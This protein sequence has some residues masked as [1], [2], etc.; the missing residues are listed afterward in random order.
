M[1]QLTVVLLVVSVAQW[2]TGLG[3]K[4]TATKYVASFQST[5]QD[6][7]MRQVGYECILI[8]GLATVVLTS[9]AFLGADILASWLFGSTSNSLLLRL[10]S[11]EIAALA[12]GYSLTA[13]L[14]GLRR[15]REVSVTSIV[16]FIVRQTLAVFLLELGWGLP[17][18]ILAWGIGDSLNSIVLAAYVKR[19]LGPPKLGFGVRKLLHF[20]APLFL[21]ETASFSWGWFDR[22]LLLPFV[23]LAEL[24]SYNVA[25]TAFG[26]LNSVT[27]SF[28]GAL[29]PFYSQFFPGEPA[30]ETADLERAIR[31][32]SRYVS[33]L[34]TP[35]LVGSAVIA[36]PA[37]T[38]LAGNGYSDA[39]V[40][41]AIVA[42]SL[43][44]ACLQG[45]LGQV[46]VVLGRTATSAAVTIMSV[47][48]AIIIGVLLVPGF[49]IQGA[50]ISRAISTILAF[51]LLVLLLRRIMKLRFDMSAYA[52]SWTASIIMAAVVVGF[53][54]LFY[55]K[56]LL[57]LYILAGA[58]T[59]VLVLR[60]LR[61]FSAEDL[62]LLS[63]LLP[64]RLR[65]L[66]NWSRRFLRIQSG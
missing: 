57:P 8:N 14:I 28:S 38:L 60:S 63:D 45:A 34:A 48:V 25:V 4:A 31:A 47:L 58:G 11:L 15:F 7:K 30:S 54:V 23:T 1:G 35:L 53:E 27:S 50:A 22:V 56:Y 3:L 39:A 55:S 18:I 16:T 62:E 6:E 40:P 64:S 21:G 24:G 9:F 52:D 13:V 46:L 12:I 20:S 65:F 10:L 66:A 5:A 17:G 51:G 61:S 36:L 33:F 32:A 44:L 41:L 19:L 26:F 43:A 59:F 2:L 42:V 49:G 29:L 37:V